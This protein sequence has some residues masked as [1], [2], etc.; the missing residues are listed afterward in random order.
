MDANGKL[1][2]L[3]ELI[4]AELELCDASTTPWVCKTKEN[5]YGKVENL[6]VDRV[7]NNGDSINSAI[8]DIEREYNLNKQND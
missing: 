6:I 3:K 4:K 2:K 5:N 8:I 1:T 7:V